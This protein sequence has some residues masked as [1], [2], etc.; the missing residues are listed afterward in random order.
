MWL[1]EQFCHPPARDASGFGE[2]TICGAQT[3]AK[4]AEREERELPVIAPGGY[5]WVPAQGERVLVLRDGASCI[6]GREQPVREELSPGDA[7]LYA[8][9]C[10]IILHA[11]GRIELTG[12]IFVNGTEISN[13]EQTE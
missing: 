11:D 7:M 3:A 8:G 10:A 2:V 6:L 13:G 4:G 12:R 5:A 1:S 9:A